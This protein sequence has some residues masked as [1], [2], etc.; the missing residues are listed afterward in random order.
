[1]LPGNNGNRFLYFRFP[2]IPGQVYQLEIDDT[3]HFTDPQ[4]VLLDSFTYHQDDSILISG[5]NQFIRLKSFALPAG[6]E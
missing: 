2:S 3:V 6:A 4:S 1:M 5:S